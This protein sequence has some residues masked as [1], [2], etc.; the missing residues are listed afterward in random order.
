MGHLPPGLPVKFT[1]LEAGD[2]TRD[3]AAAE[4]FMDMM[5]NHT[6]RRKFFRSRRGYVGMGSAGTQPGDLLCVLFGGKIPFIL[7]K[8]RD[9]GGF[10]LV[11][12]AF[13]DGAMRGETI[14]MYEKG[15]LVAHMFDLH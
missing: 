14:E 5:R 6:M 9:G 11:G 7:W 2:G 8:V 3:T 13:V 15:E 4:H 10:Y 1:T 12:D